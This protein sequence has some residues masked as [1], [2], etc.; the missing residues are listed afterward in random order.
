MF[1]TFLL[2][3]LMY[4]IPM[5]IVTTLIVFSLILI[6][7]GDPALAL[8]GDNATEDKLALL[9]SQLGLDQPVLIQYWNWLTNAV[10]G[11][12]GRSLFT[13]EIVSEAVSSRLGVTF[14]LVLASII[15][16]FVFGMIFAIASVIKPNSWVDYM[17]RFI[18]TLGTAIP[19]FWLAMLLIVFFSVNLGWLPATG[20]ISISESPVGFF[21]SV[22]LPA[23]CLGAFGAAQITRQLRSSLLE[24][25]ES[26][27]IRTAYSK[28]LLIGPIIWKHGLRNSLLPV[29]TTTG[30]L[31][32]NMLGATVVIETVFAIPGMG[33]LAV[34][35][36]LQRDFPMLQGVVLVMVVLV[37]VINFVT[38]VL[39]SV[40]DPRIEY[41]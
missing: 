5:L 14:Q 39:Y 27:Y 4:V 37:L 10:Q 11:D 29:I 20:F 18:G 2:R 28:G 9:R 12:L 40:L 32:G 19:N 36:I 17:A 30:L 41:K 1:L 26:D 15:F 25:L 33:Q 23:I 22:I 13:G 38:D 35:S 24:V 34:N 31:F 16:S 21:Q 8:L 7:P 3:R 6:I